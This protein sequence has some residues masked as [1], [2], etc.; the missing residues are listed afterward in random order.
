MQFY[1]LLTLFEIMEFGCIP[2]AENPMK[3]PFPAYLPNKEGESDIAYTKRK[4]TI[5]SLGTA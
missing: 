2:V 5:D 1:R 4:E 3:K